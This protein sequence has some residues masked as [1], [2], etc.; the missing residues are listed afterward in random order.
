MILLIDGYKGICD[1]SGN[2][3]KFVSIISDYLENNSWGAEPDPAGPCNPCGDK[4][5]YRDRHGLVSCWVYMGFE[6]R[7]L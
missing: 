2:H 5:Y 7:P 3:A 4:G 1:A 6:K